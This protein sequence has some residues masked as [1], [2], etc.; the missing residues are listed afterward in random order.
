MLLRSIASFVRFVLLFV[1]MVFLWPFL[2]PPET[3][4]PEKSNN[5]KSF[6]QALSE[7]CDIELNQLPP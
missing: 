1:R 6:A 4:V 2:A 3:V 7:F 5:N